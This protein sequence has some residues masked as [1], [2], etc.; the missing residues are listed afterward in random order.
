MKVY[1]YPDRNA[2]AEI[3]SRPVLK[4]AD[5]FQQVTD[6]LARV[7]AEGD[8]GVRHCTLQYDGVDIQDPAVPREWISE[9]SLQVKDE[10]KKAINTARGNI[11]KFHAAQ[12]II[13]R[14]IMTSPGVKCWQRAEPIEKVGLYIPGGSAPL[15]STVLMLGIPAVVA[16]CRE[17]ILCTPPDENGKVNP[18]ILY[19]AGLLGINNIFRIGGAQA[20]AAMAYGTKSVP[21]V[22]K[23]FGPGNQ[24][25][26][27]AKQMVAIEGVA[28]DLPAGPSEIAVIADHTA[29]PEFIASDLLS[30]AE[31]G[32]DSQVLL[33]TNHEPLL[34]AVANQLDIQLEKIPRKEIARESLEKS[35]FVLL[36]SIEEMIELMNTYAPEHLI[37]MIENYNRIVG[38]IKNAGSV[39]LGPYSPESAGDYASGTNHTL[40]TN[41]YARAYSGIGLESFRKVISFQEISRY[42]LFNLNPAIVQFAEAENLLAHKNA[43]TIRLGQQETDNKL[44]E[45]V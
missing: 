38:Q 32:T 10:L 20:I 27:L 11:I 36:G 28:I 34:T 43:V 29:N 30:Q 31:H 3:I 19:T 2:W 35:R 26:T 24:Y 40:P 44:Y 42:G 15:V 37:I 25:V 1:K 39:F 33:V 12:Q 23:I 6:I 14:D 8:E 7:K 41:G 16:G 9:A 18:A 17:I 45:S 5:L 21:S 13:Y 4:R 22:Y